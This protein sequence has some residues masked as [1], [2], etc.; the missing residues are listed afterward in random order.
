MQN[1]KLVKII[2]ILGALIALTVSTSYVAS[3]T[4]PPPSPYIYSG[5]VTVAGSPAPDGLEIIAHVVAPNGTDFQ[6]PFSVTVKNGKFYGLGVGTPD[7]SYGGGIVT[8]YLEGKIPSEETDVYVVYSNPTVKD[9]FSLTFPNLPI[10]TPT[11]T[12]IPTPIPT[13]IPPTPTP[14]ATIP[15]VYSGMIAVLGG[16]L[17]QDAELIASVGSYSS[18]AAVI[19]GYE[20]ANLVVDPADISLRGEAIEFFLNGIKSRT[21]SSYQSGGIHKNFYLIFSDLPTPTAIP[22]TPTSV[23]STATAVPPTSVPPTAIPPTP[24]SV[25]PTATAAPSTATAVP[26]T[27]VPPTVVPTP[28]ARIQIIIATPTPIPTPKPLLDKLNNTERAGLAI[29]V[30]AGV[31]AA[32]LFGTYIFSRFI[33]KRTTDESD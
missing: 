29:A 3:A 13:P 30:S 9:S 18:Y 10:P 31:I 5:T 16:E 25:P 19:D 12:A 17:P 2:L 21:T 20:Y 26:P 27:S 15:S 11:P 32:V 24:T 33:R 6:A 23:S 28:E 22:P 14:L 7:T 8:F 1:I 4:G